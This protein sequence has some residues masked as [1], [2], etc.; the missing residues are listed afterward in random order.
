VILSSGGIDSTAAVAL[1][2]AEK[3]DCT[4]MFVD[5]GQAAAK[6]E[7]R[8]SSAVADHYR[9]DRRVFTVSGL[10]FGSGEIRGRNSFLVNAALLAFPA[11][12][13]STQLHDARDS[14]LLTYCP[15]R[16]R[17][18]GCR[19]S[20]FSCALS[21]QRILLPA[22]RGCSEL[23]RCQNSRSQQ[24]HYWNVGSGGQRLSCAD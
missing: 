10:S 23:C 1:A 22:G 17:C 14:R 7:D 12:S 20:D 24:H 3:R 18:A 21:R 5:Y 19:R 13:G 8:S 6:A 11:K 4:T 16:T 15:S 9:V 2:V